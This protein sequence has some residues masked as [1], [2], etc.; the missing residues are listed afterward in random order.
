MYIRIIFHTVNIFLNSYYLSQ[1]ILLKELHL[2]AT[3]DSEFWASLLNL[4]FLPKWFCPID[5]FAQFVD[6]LLAPLWKIAGR[7]PCL[8]NLRGGFPGPNSWL[9]DEASA[10]L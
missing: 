7:L 5:P 6:I 9:Y 1:N 2:P 8:E 4:V 3:P 10:A